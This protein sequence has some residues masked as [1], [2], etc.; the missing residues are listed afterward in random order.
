VAAVYVWILHISCNKR[1]I[2][3]NHC[4]E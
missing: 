1:N 4:E 2:I 3:I